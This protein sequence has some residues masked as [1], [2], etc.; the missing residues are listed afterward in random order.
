LIWKRDI[1]GGA[2][3]K[4]NLGEFSSFREAV[5]D[6]SNEKASPV[7]SVLRAADTPGVLSLFEA[8]IV[9]ENLNFLKNPK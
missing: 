1:S 8:E 3:S 4:S 6:L 9:I 2:P 7:K 5:A